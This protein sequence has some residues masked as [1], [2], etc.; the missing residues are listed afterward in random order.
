MLQQQKKCLVSACLTGLCTRYDGQSKVNPACMQHLAD[1]HWIPVC[2]EQLGGLPTPRPAADLV[3]G[4]GYAVLAG[5][6]QVID[7]QGNDLSEPFIRGASMVLTIAQAQHVDCC[8]LKSGSPSCG[9]AP[10]TGVT[11]A[12]L[13]SHGIR[14]ISF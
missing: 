1:Y 13:R 6:A 10:L 5:T 14:I 11:T 8:F 2:P 7:R 4:D 9:F 12:L 3:N